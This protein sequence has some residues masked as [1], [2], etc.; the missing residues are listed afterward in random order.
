MSIQSRVEKLEQQIGEQ[1][2]CATCAAAP[3]FTFHIAGDPEHP[4]A[5]P[6]P[7][8]GREPQ[9]LEFTLDIGRPLNDSLED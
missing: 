5:G 6:C 7:E 3:P 8:C 2:D 1:S 4:Q 9:K